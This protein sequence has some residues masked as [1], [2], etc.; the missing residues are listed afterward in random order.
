MADET[1]RVVTVRMPEALYQRLKLA[2]RALGPV[3]P[4]MNWLCV[5][6]IDAYVGEVLRE[7]ELPSEETTKPPTAGT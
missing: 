4:S 6:A 1:L 5:D 2:V 3:A 7:P